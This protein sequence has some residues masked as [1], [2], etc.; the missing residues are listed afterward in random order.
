[1]ITT[2]QAYEAMRIFIHQF[3]QREPEQYRERF[4]Q[5]LRWTH[6]DSD[7]IT[8]DPAQWGDWDAAV[9]AAVAGDFI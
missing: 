1:M 6:V 7:G 5:L 4:E 9:A 8:S 3:A 2:R